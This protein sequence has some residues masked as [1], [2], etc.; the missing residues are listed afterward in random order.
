MTLFQKTWLSLNHSQ[1][2]DAH[3]HTHTHTHIKDPPT[4]KTVRGHTGGPQLKAWDTTSQIKHRV[5]T[6]HALM[7][8]SLKYTVALNIEEH[9]SCECVWVRPVEL[10]SRVRHTL[11]VAATADG[12]TLREAIY[13]KVGLKRITGVFH[14]YVTAYQFQWKLVKAAAHF[15]KTPM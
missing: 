14:T 3:T 4:Q 7:R 6:G 1:F 11:Y 12:S 13:A 9:N 2:M 5:P 8:H 10:L 15:L